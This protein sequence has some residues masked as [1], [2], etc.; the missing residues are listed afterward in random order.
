MTPEGTPVKDFL[1]FAIS[2]AVHNH[3][4]WRP[5]TTRLVRGT[6]FQFGRGPEIVVF[7]SNPEWASSCF[8]G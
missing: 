6:T 7:A 2:M 5:K 3:L 8:A 4:R 1:R